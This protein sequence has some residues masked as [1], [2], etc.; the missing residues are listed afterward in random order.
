MSKASVVTHLR[1]PEVAVRR[2][3]REKD[4]AKMARYRTVCWRYISVDMELADTPTDIT[5]KTCLK[6]IRKEKGE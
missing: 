4:W 1:Y 5:C 2:H 6:W 3:S